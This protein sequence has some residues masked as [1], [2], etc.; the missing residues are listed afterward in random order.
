MKVIRDCESGGDRKLR[1]FTQHMLISRSL[2]VVPG[3][4]RSSG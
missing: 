1:I 3:Q 2:Q 4:S